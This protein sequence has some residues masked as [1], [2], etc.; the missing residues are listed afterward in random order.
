MR[1]IY[2]CWFKEGTEREKARKREREK[3]RKRER[4]KERKREREKEITERKREQREQV[5]RYS[6]EGAKISTK[7]VFVFYFF[8]GIP[9]KSL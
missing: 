8:Q 2:Q 9:V 3:E 5:H 1:K 7:K 6:W 4:E